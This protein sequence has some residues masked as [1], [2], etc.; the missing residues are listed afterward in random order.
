MGAHSKRASPLYGQPVRRGTASLECNLLENYINTVF[1]TNNYTCSMSSE[2]SPFNSAPGSPT[3]LLMS[4]TTSDFETEGIRP[5]YREVSQE[6]VLGIGDTELY[7]DTGVNYMQHSPKK[8]Q[9]SPPSSDTLGAAS[10]V[11]QQQDS[12]KSTVHEP[13]GTQLPPITEETEGLRI[14]DI[15]KL[16]A[17]MQSNHNIQVK[18]MQDNFKEAMRQ[19]QI[20]NREL[21]SQLLKVREETKNVMGGG[22]PLGGG[23]FGEGGA[24][25]D[26]GHI[27]GTVRENIFPT[28]P[29]FDPA[30][31][32]KRES[33]T[34]TNLTGAGDGGESTEKAIDRLAAVLERHLVAPQHTARLPSLTLPKLIKSAGDQIEGTNFFSFKKRCL[35]LFEEH[36]IGESIAVHL[37]QTEETLPKRFRQSLNNCTTVQACFKTMES[38]T[39]PLTAVYPQLL[40]ELC[41]V[42]SAFDNAEQIQLCDNVCR[43]LL[44]MFEHYPAQDIQIAHVTAVLSAFSTQH[45]INTLPGVVASFQH[46]HTTT[47]KKFST[48]LYEHCTQRRTDLYSI[49]AALD[50]WRKDDQMHNLMKIEDDVSDDYD[51]EDEDE[52]SDEFSY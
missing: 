21:Q 12:P 7:H 18:E 11:T 13:Q 15:L 28:N 22:G 24:G 17:Q 48:L 5:D 25:A 37:L 1:F 45:E 43:I 2:S 36:N 26:A 19:Q 3:P 14:Q 33:R 34:T 40:N 52:D 32:S 9:Q 47:N 49:M 4:L 23:A 46:K 29:T 35:Q 39:E 50:M 27:G 10:A 6:L 44:Q 42:E 38:M 30:A 51:E 20:A 16:L 31:E 8:T 41:S